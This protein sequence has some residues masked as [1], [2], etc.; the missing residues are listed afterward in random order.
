MDF[1]LDY[2]KVNILLTEEFYESIIAEID[3]TYPYSAGTVFAAQ[4]FNEEWYNL[5][6]AGSV[7]HQ[8]AK[9]YKFYNLMRRFSISKGGGKNGKLVPHWASGQEYILCSGAFEMAVT[10]HTVDFPLNFDLDN[11][12]DKD[13]SVYKIILCTYPY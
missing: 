2:V 6:G 9:G 12:D 7:V 13:Y 8:H 10:P 1:D 3:S 5:F 4:V 11:Y